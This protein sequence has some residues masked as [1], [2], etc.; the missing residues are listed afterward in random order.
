M[1]PSDKEKQVEIQ[2]ESQEINTNK[3]VKVYNY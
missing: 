3:T 2:L 1:N